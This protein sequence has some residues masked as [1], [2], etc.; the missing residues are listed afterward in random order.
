MTIGWWV[1][2]AGAGMMIIAIVI[3]LAIATIDENKDEM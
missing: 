3:V 2:I 1:L